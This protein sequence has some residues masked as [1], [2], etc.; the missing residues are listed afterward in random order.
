VKLIIPMAGMGKRMRP[1]TLTIPKPL[2]EIAGK[3]IVQRLVEEIGSIVQEKIEEIAFITGRFGQ[4]IEN[5]LISIAKR[6]GAKGIICY[7]DQALGTAHAIYCAEKLLNGKVLVAFADTLFHADFKIDDSCDGIIWV[8]KVDDPSQFGVVKIDSNGIITDFIEKPKQPVSDLA[9]IGIYYFKDGNIL[10]QELK[11]LLDNNVTVK[12]E[13]QLTDALE[14]MKQ[15]QMIFKTAE[16]NEWLDCGNVQATIDTQCRVLELVK[17]K[18]KLVSN[19][20]KQTNSVIIEPCYL[21]EN[22]EIENSIIGPYVSVAKNTRIKS[23]VISASIINE[24]SIISSLILKNSFIGKETIVES[25]EKKI[26]IG[27]YSKIVI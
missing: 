15:K 6:L 9:I 19:T 10:K 1:H 3:S 8:K 24:S 4:D 18:E 27:D 20:V 5:Q 17:Q 7:Q 23:S 16:V 2:I 11:Y 21:G 22:V 14:N 26:D 25:V 12:G 13:Y